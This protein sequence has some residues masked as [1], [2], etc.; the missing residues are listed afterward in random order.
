MIICESVGPGTYPFTWD[1]Q[2]LLTVTATTWDGQVVG[3]EWEDELGNWWPSAA[4]GELS[5]NGTHL[6]VEEHAAGSSWRFLVP[7]GMASVSATIRAPIT[8]VPGGE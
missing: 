6:L 8:Y 4:A 3:W 1:G 7:S 5:A 2:G